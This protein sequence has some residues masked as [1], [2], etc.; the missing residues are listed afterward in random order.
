M[1]AVPVY[2]QRLVFQVTEKFL[3]ISL[4]AEAHC[5]NISTGDE[6]N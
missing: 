4:V 2:E 3:P 1:N 5:S 6:N